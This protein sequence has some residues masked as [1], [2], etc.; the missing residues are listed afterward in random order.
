MVGSPEWIP[1]TADS[2]AHWLLHV[3][4][5]PTW[6]DSL[7]VTRGQT[8]PRTHA[9]GVL[10]SPVPWPSDDVVDQVDQLSRRIHAERAALGDQLDRLQ[11]LVDAFAAGEIDEVGLAAAVAALSGAPR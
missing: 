10:D 11:A 9:E 6:R 1:L 2:G 4:R 7:P 5:S 8:R 3:L